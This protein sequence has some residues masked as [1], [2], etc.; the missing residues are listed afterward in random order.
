MLVL[1]RLTLDDM[2]LRNKKPIAWNPEGWRKL[3]AFFKEVSNFILTSLEGPRNAQQDHIIGGIEAKLN[4][5]ISLVA[6][7][8]S[9][10]ARRPTI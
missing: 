6:L 4:D 10:M 5:T 1:G 3:L 8:R 7:K 2:L 9:S